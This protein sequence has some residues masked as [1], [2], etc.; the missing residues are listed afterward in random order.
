MVVSGFYCQIEDHFFSYHI[1]TDIVDKGSIEFAG[2]H[3][4]LFPNVEKYS[5]WGLSPNFLT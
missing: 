4:D 5:T 2:I 3:R 1:P